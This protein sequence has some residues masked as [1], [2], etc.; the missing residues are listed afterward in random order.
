ML[1]QVDGENIKTTKQ[2]P[3]KIHALKSAKTALIV[4]HNA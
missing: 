4:R 1:D 3:L 2:H